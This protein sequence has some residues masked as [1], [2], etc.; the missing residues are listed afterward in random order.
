[1][2]LSTT[3]LSIHYLSIYPSSIINPSIHPSIH[4]L[5]MYKSTIY[6]SYLQFIDLSIHPLF[7][8]PSINLLLYLSLCLSVHPSISPRIHPSIHPSDTVCPNRVAVRTDLVAA[9]F[10]PS[11]GFWRPTTDQR[12][13]REGRGLWQNTGRAVVRRQTGAW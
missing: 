5:P 12:V 10:E 6:P 9:L 7:I 11:R 8:P 13:D 1:M 3:K 2:Y 4:H